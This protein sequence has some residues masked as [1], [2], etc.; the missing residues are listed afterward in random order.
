MI[1]KISKT[2]KTSN[3]RITR[4]LAAA[5]L[6]TSL[7]VL[8]ACGDDE[9]TTEAT[10]AATAADTTPVTDVPAASGD[11]VAVASATQ[12]FTTL[13]A[14]VQAA[15]LVETLQG[16]GPFTVFAPT[17]DAF[18]ALPAGLLDALLLPENQGVLAQIL[19]YHVVSGK[20]MAADVVAGDV[21]TVEGSSLTITTDGGVKIFDANVVQTDVEAT[22]GV[23]HVIDQVLVPEGVDID[24]LLAAGEMATD[25]T[26]MAAEMG[27]IV[28][29]ATEAGSFATLL[30]A[31]EA[32][33]LVETLQSE[34]PFTVFAPTDEA[35]AALPAGLVDT[36]LLPENKD[37]LAQVLTYHVV[38]GKVL[39]ADVA[40][41]EVASVQ[42]EPI[43]VT[44]DNGGVQVNGANVVAVDVEASN[45]V[46]H[47]IDA[48]ILPPSVDVSAL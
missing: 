26:A 40:A 33:G 1:S 9:E 47:V 36:L 19:T 48:V 35:F 2:S 28:A 29:V 18:A 21:P 22:N 43:T 24:A 44:T 3:K 14:A 30:A 46:I 38:A 41:G 25:T 17:D 39:S 13:V 16:P 4:K 7:L 8:A 27:D 11:I 32:A 23:I 20:V 31:A 37:L 45:G 6:A 10:T 5:G 12:G 15:G 42:G 34:G